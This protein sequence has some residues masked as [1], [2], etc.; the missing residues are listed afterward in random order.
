MRHYW[1][2]IRCWFYRVKRDWPWWVACRLPKRVTLM[3][4]VLVYGI[5]GECGPEYERA[6]KLWEKKYG[7]KP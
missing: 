6:Y 4:F 5:L 7:L 3:A 1:L 2:D